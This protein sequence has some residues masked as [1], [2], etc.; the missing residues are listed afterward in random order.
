MEGAAEMMM[1]VFCEG[2]GIPVR[3]HETECA[4]CRPMLEAER[5]RKKAEQRIPPID[6]SN[7]GR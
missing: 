6:R 1:Y 7:G 5:R 4:R 3:P 2:C